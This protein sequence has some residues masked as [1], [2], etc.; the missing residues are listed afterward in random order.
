M[1]SVLGIVLLFVYKDSA[2]SVEVIPDTFVFSPIVDRDEGSLAC[3]IGVTNSSECV[4]NE[5]LHLFLRGFRK[6]EGVIGVGEVL[7]DNGVIDRPGIEPAVEGL[8]SRVRLGDR[9]LE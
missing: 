5:L 2:P 7:R 3:I 9:L 8:L 1:L 4:S 6:D